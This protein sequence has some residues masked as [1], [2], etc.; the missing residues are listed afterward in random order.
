MTASVP[1][2]GRRP[3][4]GPGTGLLSR[5][6]VVRTRGSTRDAARDLH[7]SDRGASAP[8]PRSSGDC[9]RGNGVGLSRSWVRC[10]LSPSPLW[11]GPA[12]YGG[13]DRMCPVAV[14]SVEGVEK[15]CPCPAARVT[16]QW[17]L[18]P[19][20]EVPSNRPRP[21]PTPEPPVGEVG[22]PSECGH[23]RSRPMVSGRSPGRKGGPGG[24]Y[25]ASRPAFKP[26]PATRR[27]CRRPFALAQSLEEGRPG[28]ATPS[29]RQSHLAVR[30]EAFG[31]LVRWAAPKRN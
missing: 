26:D 3:C 20:F 12:Q 11:V 4:A 15:T 27:S 17:P 29:V 28:Q 10:G 7:D 6:R 9:T 25:A 13:G 23:P 30:R 24:R 22:R 31:F 1:G 19:E 14:D 2:A 5:T 21:M 16:Q 8:P 18:V